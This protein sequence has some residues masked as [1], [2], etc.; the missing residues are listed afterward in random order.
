MKKIALLLPI[1]GLLFSCNNVEKADDDSYK[2]G[3]PLGDDKTYA[4]FMYNYPRVSDE[5]ANGMG[6]MYD[7]ALYYKEEIQV[8]Q[9]IAEPAEE[10]TREKYE[11]QGWFRESECLNPWSFELDLA[12]GSTYLYAKWGVTQGEDYI[13][14][15]YIY[16]ERILDDMDTNNYVVTGILNKP[17][18][19]ATEVDLT[20]G[21]IN[22]LKRSPSD[23]SF[24]V[25]YQRKAN[26]TLTVATFNE[27]TMT[28]H[29][30]TSSSD[31]FNIHVNDITSTL[32][33]QTLFPTQKWVEGFETKAKNYE[34]AEYDLGNYH[35]ALGGSSS[36]E[37]WS[38]STE[39]MDPI[40][41]FNHGIGG[42]TVENWTTC[43]LERL[44]TPYCPKVVA[45]YV[46]VNN[47]INDNK[48][49]DET[50]AALVALFDKTH[51]MLPEAK[52]LFVMINKL[53]GYPS[54]QN[55]FDTANRYALEYAQS[56]DYLVC[57]DAGVGLLKPNGQPHYGYF[58]SDGLHMSK[59]G[60]VIWGAAVKKAIMDILG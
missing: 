58:C 52:I 48:K 51:Q 35:V 10:P 49:G 22:R 41:S 23:V 19:T 36:M 53:P 57:L 15:E 40:V 46:G 43:L 25:N 50:G 7:N 8:G 56:H 24:A 30:E 32:N 20:L 39:D 44:I 9:L 27:E 45:Y 34:N 17:L 18:R 2:P 1:L 6:E 13:E 54:Y 26:V 59:Y 16:P 12:E 33:V 42:T 29:L 21:A 11:F 47:I 31:V 5:S 3:R 38:T 37:N 4:L 60:Y 14:P 28:I 55:E